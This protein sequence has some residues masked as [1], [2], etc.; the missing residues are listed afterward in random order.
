M[1]THIR[2]WAGSSDTS[3]CGWTVTLGVVTAVHGPLALPTAAPS[4]LERRT[5]PWTQ[6][7]SGRSGRPPNQKSASGRGGAGPEERP[8]CEPGAPGHAGDGGE[9]SPQPGTQGASGRPGPVRRTW[10]CWEWIT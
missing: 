6:W 3:A 5:S 7:R 4:S 9:D 2:A 1:A 10:S 8:G